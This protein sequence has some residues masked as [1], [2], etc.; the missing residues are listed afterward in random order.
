M[1]LTRHA[2]NRLRWIRRAEPDL[3]EVELLAAI[4]RGASIGRDVRDNQH[5][6]VE[7][8][9]VQLVLVVDE[10]EQIVITMWREE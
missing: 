10:S 4:D 8:G 7:V 5:V 6:A 9:G 1:R 3:A 2:K